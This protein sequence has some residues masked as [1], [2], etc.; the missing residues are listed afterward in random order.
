MSFDF[1]Y[2]R[3]KLDPVFF[4]VCSK[5]QRSHFFDLFRFFFLMI[6]SFFLSHFTHS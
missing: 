3:K 1:S 6:I 2:D 5:F 4:S